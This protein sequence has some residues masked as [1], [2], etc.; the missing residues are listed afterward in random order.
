MREPL[1]NRER[2]SLYSY[3]NK[4]KRE[5]V[6][7]K[8]LGEGSNC[9]AYEVEDNFGLPFILKECCPYQGTSRGND[10]TVRWEADSQRDAAF[11]RF[12]RSFEIQRE[13]QRNHSTENTNAQLVDGLFCA[14]NTLYTLASHKNAAV[15]S[16]GK[17]ESLQQVFITARAIA[18]AVAEYHSA[19]FLHLDIKPDNVMVY[20]ETR[21]MI[22]LLD[23]DSVIEKGCVSS[24]ES[25][26]YSP[27][28]CAPEQMRFLRKK[29]CEATDR[30]AIGAIVF[31]R[32][33]NRVPDSTDTGSF[34]T[35]DF[36]NNPLFQ[37]MSGTVIR[38]TR[39]FLHLTL[40]ASPN[41]RYSS[42]TALIQALDKLIA[43]SD[44][45]RNFIVS[46]DI[47]S[48]NMFFGRN[49]ELGAI[50]N[51]LLSCI[52]NILVLH[53]MGG[54]GKTELAKRAA[55]EMRDCFDTICFGRY[56]D[57]LDDLFHDSHFITLSDGASPEGMT[58]IKRY[59]D[60]RTLLIIDNLDSL[61][62][63]QII[64]LPFLPCKVLI[65]S[66]CD[67]SD[68]YS[69]FTQ[70][71]VSKMSDEDQYALFVA[72]AGDAVSSDDKEVVSDIL[73]TIDGYT[74]MIPLI[75]KLLRKGNLTLTA[76]AQRIRQAGIASIPEDK[77]RHTKDETIN[78]S[79]IGIL[80]EVLDM[81][82]FSD[83]ENYVMKS[84]LL[85]R[86]I[87]IERHGLLNEIGA[88]YNDVL[89][90]LV[91][92][93]WLQQTG[94]GPHAVFSMHSVIAQVY[95]LDHK[96]RLSE[97]A[98]MVNSMK[99]FSQSCDAA[100]D[101]LPEDKNWGTI[102]W[103][104][105]ITGIYYP[106]IINERE[107]MNKVP[108]WEHIVYLLIRI[109]KFADEEVSTILDF[110]TSVS[111]YIFTRVH[112][113]TFGGTGILRNI[114]AE[115]NLTWKQQAK[116]DYLIYLFDLSSLAVSD[117]SS[118]EIRP[119]FEEATRCAKNTLKVTAE[120]CA[121]GEGLGWVYN[122]IIETFCEIGTIYGQSLFGW[123]EDCVR[124][125]K[126][127]ANAV[128]HEYLSLYE[129]TYAD[130]LKYRM[131]D[132]NKCID[133]TKKEYDE[134]VEIQTAAPYYSEKERA[135]L[136]S[137][138]SDE[139]R[140]EYEK[141]R[142]CQ[143]ILGQIRA[144]IMPKEKIL[145]RV[146]LIEL[147]KKLNIAKAI[148]ETMNHRKYAWRLSQPLDDFV[149]YQYILYRTEEAASRLYCLLGNKPK[150]VSAFK[151]YL[152]YSSWYSEGL[153]PEFRGE[154]IEDLFNKGEESCVKAMAI[155]LLRNY[156]KV[157]EEELG[158]YNTQE[159]RV[160][161]ILNH[162]IRLSIITDDPEEI[163][164]YRKRWMT[165]NGLPYF[166]GDIQKRIKEFDV[167]TLVS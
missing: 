96:P 41:R 90:D 91:E 111:A 18:R 139:E 22:L 125:F 19:G 73:Q 33:F 43:L 75:A 55:R 166:H 82:H 123:H 132:L 30:F 80:R 88:E 162:Q 2:L 130:E 86:D 155:L 136:V 31:S 142:A 158:L 72:L 32:I 9:I 35:W 4:S 12:R 27:G 79:V 114:K 69:D 118:M 7:N 21:D 112:N 105:W 157:L 26:S 103:M 20:P 44:P 45:R 84:L 5:I 100:F 161:R 49:K 6:I 87:Y 133:F 160:A 10:S 42:D 47:C 64:E 101:S 25:L 138:L 51:C 134:K 8:C 67:F 99:A 57:S 147:E 52:S 70:I 121:P 63:R 23:F 159:D 144:E 58:G 54:I 39:D 119:L 28:F 104:S 124:D 127:F 71:E 3:G 135:Q 65:T 38:L 148:A 156:D 149:D 145:D 76:L 94:S 50:R 29:I 151:A 53:G 24:S 66:R 152:D 61:E 107:Q 13:F 48:A 128:A 167:S 36:E 143:V 141:S 115:N 59:L 1:K 126:E 97:L 89:N 81:S 113:F 40:A 131:Q 62:D 46:T 83:E 37:K 140:E 120:H 116:I 85:F 164:K 150:A 93:G 98:W 163:S 106:L 34:S 60:D 153:K 102:D 15:Y 68:A 74:L 95:E 109:G 17:D 117:H 16:S 165:F 78:D 108:R 154:L 77:I 11:D 129:G 92:S 137:L 14:N 110:Y 146:S 122:H 56:R